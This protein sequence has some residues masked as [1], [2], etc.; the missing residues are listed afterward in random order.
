MLYFDSNFGEICSYGSIWQ[1][2]NVVSSEYSVSY[3]WQV[4]I[5]TNN[6]LVYWRIC[7]TLGVGELYPVNSDLNCMTSILSI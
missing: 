6:G 1:R 3:L 2:D 7:A 5:Q 4:I